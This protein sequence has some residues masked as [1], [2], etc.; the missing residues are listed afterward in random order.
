MISLYCR[1]QEAK[2]YPRLSDL[3]TIF[4]V[5]TLDITLV[6]IGL[7][8]EHFGYYIGDVTVFIGKN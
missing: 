1:A 4:G 6:I 7:K 5:P 8:N 3:A 2:I